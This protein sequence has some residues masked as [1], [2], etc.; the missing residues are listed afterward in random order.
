MQ[1]RLCQY[2]NLVSGQ[3]LASHNAKEGRVPNE[4]GGC[5]MLTLTGKVK[6]VAF[7]QNPTFGVCTKLPVASNVYSAASYEDN[8]VT[9]KTRS[10]SC[11][12][13]PTAV[14]AESVSFAHFPS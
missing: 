14:S 1:C 3:S 4:I 2:S 10:C 9:R 7:E 13:V 11:I 6:Y 8:Y 5:S 12:F